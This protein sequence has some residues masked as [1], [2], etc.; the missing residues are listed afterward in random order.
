RRRVVKAHRIAGRCGRGRSAHTSNLGT[1][2]HARNL[3]PASSLQ[4]FGYPQGPPMGGHL[5]MRADPFLL[6]RGAPERRYNRRPSGTE[7]P[8]VRPG[9]LLAVALL[10]LPLA[11]C[12]LL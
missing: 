12:G 9:L 2:D 1:W 11:G 6:D 7:A 3:E 10:T 8:L 5:T 4:L